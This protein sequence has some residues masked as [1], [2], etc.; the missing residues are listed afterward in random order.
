MK[1]RLFAIL[2]VL[3]FSGCAMLT[4]IDLNTLYGPTEA[5]QR[6][7]VA[8][9][10][11]HIDYW[12]DVKPITDKRCIVC[13][14]C[15]DA[16]CQ[17]KMTAPE[18][19]VRG[20][21]SAKVY[22]PERLRA[23]PPTRL[24]EDTQLASEWRERDF[25]PVL[26]EHASSLAANRQASVL[27]QMLALKKQHPLPSGTVLPEAFTL[28]LNRT[29]SCP[30]AEEFPRFAEKNPLWGMPYGF[31]SLSDH[32]HTTLT[33]W[34]DEGAEYTQRQPL[35][36][37]LQTQV[38]HWETF[39]NDDSLKS[40]LSSRYIYEHLFL[41]HIYFSEQESPQFFKLVRS[42]TP[43]G[44]EISLIATRRPYDHPGVE[45]VYYRLTP[46]KET[47]VHKTHMPYAFNAERMKRWQ[48]LFLDANYDVTE[49][50]GYTLKIAGNP[51]LAFQDLPVKS[52]YKFMLDEAQFSIMNFIKGPVC[53]GNVALNVIKD[54]FWVFFTDPE[55]NG[56]EHTANFLQRHADE[57]EM[58][59][60]KGDINRVFSSWNYYSKKQK[61]LMEARDNYMANQISEF[62]DEINLNLIWD[63]GKQNSNAAL[64][65]FRHFDSATVEQGLIGPPP[66]TAWVIG[67]PLLERI[68]YLLVA[69][70][71][72]YGN[73]GHQ[74]LSRLYMDFLRMEGESNFL[75]LLP[76][77]ARKAE[78]ENWYRGA[79]PKVMEYLTHPSLEERFKT[80]IAFLTNQ[81]KA[82]L[83]E[84]IAKHLG[85][86][87]PKEHS[88]SAIS[89]TVIAEQL[90]KLETLE[91]TQTRFLPQ[92]MLLI[93]EEQSP[94][95]DTLQHHASL[96][97][98]TAHLNITSMF[99]ENQNLIESENTVTVANGIV[100]SYPNV[101]IKVRID[102]LPA[103][104]KELKTL[105]SAQDYKTMLDQ[106]GV[107][108]TNRDFWEISD[109][110]HQQ[111]AKDAPIGFGYLDYNRFENR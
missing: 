45:R 80:N 40:K 95:G 26:N 35:S 63:G 23:A 89:N 64:T 29:Q 32:E 6:T 59:N 37:A 8:L 10:E 101:F 9:P 81:P 31:P 27:Y 79:S 50:P 65:V 93:I 92:Q 13:H 52:R 103:L 39:L 47:I 99:K 51:F 98:N 22:H 87:L 72:V 77:D 102:Q 30:K 91:G 42:S 78:R 16:P 110:V 28:D 107:R 38:K 100:G 41:A 17:L 73:L 15:Y 2:S 11:N 1:F 94:T 55:F 60:A 49:L 19:I 71:D 21:S 108:R 83:F 111:F 33:Q 43:P 82:E 68:H 48:A 34:I 7:L 104:V 90:Q 54:H 74:L 85:A 25:F 12:Q 5:K 56:A 24:F 18:G 4:N 109:K 70:Y 46:E 96:L 106:F 62:P 88:I 69:G 75:M 36:P 44:Q 58:P 97:K 84:L 66:Q 20:A 76:K 105:H 14:A 61:S 86:A 57:Y 67:Y 53:R 3:L